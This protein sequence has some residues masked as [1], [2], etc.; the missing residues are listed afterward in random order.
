MTRWPKTRLA[1]TAKSRRTAVATIIDRP[2]APPL[3][4]RLDNAKEA[5]ARSIAAAVPPL[6]WPA[7]ANRPAKGGAIAPATPASAT[8]AIPLWLR[9]N[10]APLSQSGAAVQKALK[11]PNIAA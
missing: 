10:G 8:Q 9:L 11:A 3:R 1:E 7:S 2:K 6:A 5:A 4:A